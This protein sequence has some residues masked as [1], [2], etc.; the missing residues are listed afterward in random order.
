MGIHGDFRGQL[1]WETSSVQE[2]IMNN[3]LDYLLWVPEVL[4][5]WPIPG[6]LFGGA[7]ETVTDTLFRALFGKIGPKIQTQ[8][9]I[10]HSS[11][12]R[13]E[14]RRGHRLPSD[15]IFCVKWR[16]TKANDYGM[17]ENGPRHG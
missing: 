15:R 16:W 9:I 13:A 4:E 12:L 2:R 11:S 1:F 7:N 10:I 5:D 8:S 17:H 14:S 6:V 3:L